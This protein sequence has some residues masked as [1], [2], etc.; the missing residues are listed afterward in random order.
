MRWS[1]SDENGDSLI[2]KVEIRGVKESSWQLLK[3]DVKEKYLSWDT[4]AFPDG[5]YVI[6]VTASDSSSNPKEQALEDALV[7]DPFLV[8]NTPPQI[9][10]LAG[11]VSGNDIDVRFAAH[12]ARSDITK[13]EYSINGGDWMV[14]DPVSKLSDSPQ[15]EYH[16][17]IGRAA[18]GEQV[19][20]VRVTD[21]F[22]NQAVEKVVV[23]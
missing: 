3:A 23:K 19:V 7:S 15:E 12:D 11:T 9:S 6:R 14:V 10:N 17:V 18:P 22:D 13:A 16:L 20:A 8:D 4:T 21:E 1:A 2:Y 5:E